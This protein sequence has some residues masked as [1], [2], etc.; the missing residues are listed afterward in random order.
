MR[1]HARTAKLL[2]STSFL[3]IAIFMLLAG[4]VAAKKAQTGNTSESV[5]AAQSSE[6]V[7]DSLPSLLKEAEKSY[8]S[9]NKLET[10]EKLK[11]AILN[12]WNEVPLTIKNV[13]L[14]EDTKTYVTRKSNNFGSGEKIHVNAQIFGYQ[15]KR[16]G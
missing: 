10:V 3:A 7:Y 11:Q 6:T 2:L 8:L 13:R 9:G 4:V 12:I 5:A 15:L 16:V 14:V 1:N